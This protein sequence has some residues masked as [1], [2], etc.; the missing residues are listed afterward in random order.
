MLR[1]GLVTACGGGDSRGGGG[2]MHA[3]Q[4]SVRSLGFAVFLIVTPRASVQ[5]EKLTTTGGFTFTPWVWLPQRKPPPPCMSQG[6]T[7]QTAECLW[8][9][10]REE[11]A[12]APHTPRPSETAMGGCAWLPGLQ[13]SQD[14]SEIRIFMQSNNTNVDGCLPRLDLFQ[15]LCIREPTEPSEQTYEAG[16]CVTSLA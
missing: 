7:T 11:Q 9:G 6:L 10:H 2:G 16:V 1:E 14:R 4:T 15:V 12:P 8:E 3:L 5:A 13:A